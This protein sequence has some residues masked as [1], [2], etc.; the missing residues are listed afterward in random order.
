MTRAPFTADVLK[1]I[2]KGATSRDLGWDEPFYLSICRKHGLEPNVY[3]P[4]SHTLSEI[5]ASLPAPK[6]KPT[7]PAAPLLP[8]EGDVTFYAST[9]EVLRGEHRTTLSSRVADVFAL[10]CKGTPQIPA[11][12]RRIAERLSLP[13]IDSGIGGKVT[14]IRNRLRPLNLNVIAQSGRVNSGYWIAD[15][16]SAE[17]VKV[18]VLR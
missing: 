7:K 5:A 13:S 16:R 1:W 9:R 14:V 3:T 17:L 2:A 8:A 18:R 6:A 11:N 12:G 4:K 15:I 10:I